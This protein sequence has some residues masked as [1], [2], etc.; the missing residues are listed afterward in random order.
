VTALDEAG[1]D[2]EHIGESSTL[3]DATLAALK[4]ARLPAYKKLH[5]DI[6]NDR[7]VAIDLLNASTW[8][9]AYPPVTKLQMPSSLTPAK[10]RAR[11]HKIAGTTLLIEPLHPIPPG[12]VR[13]RA[14]YEKTYGAVAPEPADYFFGVRWSRTEE[15]IAD[16]LLHPTLYNQAMSNGRSTTDPTRICHNALLPFIP[17]L[18]EMDVLQ[19]WAAAHKIQFPAKCKRHP[20]TNHGITLAGVEEFTCRALAEEQR[21]YLRPP[22]THE[23]VDKHGSVDPQ[24]FDCVDASPTPFEA[25]M[26]VLT[27]LNLSDSVVEDVGAQIANDQR[28]K[29]LKYVACGH[30]NV[31]SIVVQRAI[32]DDGSPLVLVTADTTASQRDQ[33][34]SCR[35]AYRVDDDGLCTA[36]LKPPA[37][38][39]SCVVASWYCA[40]QLALMAFTSTVGVLAKRLNGF[41]TRY[42]KKIACLVDG[43]VVNLG[44]SRQN[45]VLRRSTWSNKSKG[46][47]AQGLAWVSP[48]GFLLVNSSLFNGRL[49][50]KDT[51]WLHRELLR[52]FPRGY[53][54]L[55][56]RGFCSCTAAYE[57]LVQC[58]FP[59]F[60]KDLCTSNIID[61]K[62]QS[63]DRYVVETFFSRVKEFR[64]LS[65]TVPVER[66]WMIESAWVCALAATD[67]WPRCAS[68]HPGR[69]RR[70]PFPWRRPPWST[71]FSRKLLASPCRGSSQVPC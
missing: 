46:N 39:C 7:A 42:K 56:D 25:Q 62:K 1:G 63:A 64:V 14:W 21:P 49:S 60:A 13:A 28:L 40:H 32:L 8:S 9:F 12:A 31:E 6:M 48:A 29:S 38:S 55:V 44:T 26:A 57:H 16:N 23:V 47:A 54:Q 61:A 33:V 43:T 68:R 10:K 15:V 22:L 58:F 65:V 17:Q 35:A 50:E 4:R 36:W 24:P 67:L 51:V 18:C 45:S 53:G 5:A 70:Q 2:L 20:V 30:C 34:Y 37:S 52:V 71:A 59:A 3:Q 66:V 69:R 19:D 27:K 41:T 11:L